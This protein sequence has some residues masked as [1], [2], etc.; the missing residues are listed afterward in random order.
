MREPSSPD[1]LV[2]G[3]GIASGL[4]AKK[5]RPIFQVGNAVD[6]NGALML[7]SL[8]LIFERNGPVGDYVD[9]YPAC[10]SRGIGTRLGRTRLQGKG[11]ILFPPGAGR[12]GW[13]EAWRGGEMA[14]NSMK[15]SHVR[16]T[17][18]QRCQNI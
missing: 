15:L 10:L 12:L 7:T 5:C 8:T 13:G 6:L 14:A 3:E 16:S 1:S 11:L 17:R 18:E 9:P 2:N 4:A